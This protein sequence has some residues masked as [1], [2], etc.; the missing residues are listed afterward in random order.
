MNFKFQ[1]TEINIDI[2]GVDS[3]SI[4]AILQQL[5]LNLNTMYNSTNNTQWSTN[6]NIK[7]VPSISW[8][9]TKSL[10]NYNDLEENNSN[11][12][13]DFTNRKAKNRLP[14][15][16]DEEGNA[17]KVED[18]I[19]SYKDFMCVNCKQGLMLENKE[20]I[21]FKDPMNNKIYMANRESLSFNLGKLKDDGSNK[22][23]IINRLSNIAININDLVEKITLQSNSSEFELE[24]LAYFVKDDTIFYTCPICGNVESLTTY[25]EECENLEHEACEVCGGEKE[26]VI[27]TGEFPI[28]QCCDCKFVFNKVDI[29][30]ENEEEIID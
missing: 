18:M 27:K 17:V 3:N 10:N 2:E 29:I 22:E 16:Y 21:I 4:I 19:K 12:D 5:N 25:I 1:N 28:M 9:D 15:E 8:E 20:K 14:N 7:D 23:D 11:I 24:E 26:I 13:F 30:S 6:Q